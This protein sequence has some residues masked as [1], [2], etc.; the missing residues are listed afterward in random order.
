MILKK[1]PKLTSFVGLILLVCSLIL[2]IYQFY[3]QRQLSGRNASNS[4]ILYKVTKII[5]GDTI[6]VAP[7][8]I[9]RLLG[10][11]A[12]ELSFCKGQEAKKELENLQNKQVTL[13]HTLKDKYHRTLALVWL[14]D[15]LINEHL[16]ARGLARFDGVSIS[17]SE[18]LQSAYQKAKDEKIGIFSP[19]CY[20]E[21]P[22]NPSCPIKGN[23]DKTT[24]RKTYHFPG[25]RE[26][27][28]AIIEKDLGETW[29]CTEL[30]ASQ[31]GFTKSQNCYDHNFNSK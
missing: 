17:E 14:D 28:T 13:T 1:I 2:N 23:I 15:I 10:V 29:F 3:K 6:E 18:R 16:I 7:N 19:L 24:S 27:S 30:E 4:I 9:V 31:A 11:Q 25:C 5:D 22:E 8:T 26:Y 12:P 20:Q 21:N